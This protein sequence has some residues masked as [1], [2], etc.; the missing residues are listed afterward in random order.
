VTKQP[1]RFAKLL[2][3]AAFTAT[4]LATAV[5]AYCQEPSKKSESPEAVKPAVADT[6]SGFQPL[7][8][9]WEAASFGGDGAVEFKK[10]DGGG[11]AIEMF[12]GDPITGI[13]WTG[14]FPKENYELRLQARRVEGFDFFAAVTFPVAD[15]HCSFVLGG[16]GGGMVGI[17]SIDGDDASSNETTQYKE[18]ETNQWYTIRVRVDQ[19]AI[20]CWIDENEFATVPRDEH[21]FSIRIEMDPC[22]PVGIANYMTRSEIKNISWRLIPAGE[23]I[24][25]ET[26]VKEVA[27]KESSK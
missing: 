20:R 22:L 27:T 21:S 1:H 13:R 16:W 25:P 26:P 19:Q 5:P 23:T 24:A 17:S 2:T 3:I 12:A 6:K 8:G 7:Q 4:C 11:E 9:R 15:E 14:D 10:L 18:F